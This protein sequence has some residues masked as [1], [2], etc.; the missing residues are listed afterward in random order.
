MADPL[1][2]VRRL[3]DEHGEASRTEGCAIGN[4]RDAPEDAMRA[5]KAAE[6]ILAIVEQ[7]A[8]RVR[9]LE[10]NA[11]LARPEGCVCEPKEWGGS[12]DYAVCSAFERCL[13]P[14]VCHCCEHSVR[15]HNG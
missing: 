6:A 11:G 7:L 3:L 12:I 15:C 9:E 1:A 10:A 5:S 2:T 14:D 4:G 13:R 8:N